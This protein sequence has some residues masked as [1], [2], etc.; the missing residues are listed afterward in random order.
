M[1]T[2]PH[3]DPIGYQRPIVRMSYLWFWTCWSHGLPVKMLWD[4]ALPVDHP[5]ELR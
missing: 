2:M 5:P 1:R 4:I 3:L